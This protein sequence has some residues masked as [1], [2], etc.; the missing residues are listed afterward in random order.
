MQ[1]QPVER[2]AGPAR[3]Q[4]AEVTQAQHAQQAH[5][6]ERYARAAGFP[7]LD[8]A[9]ADAEEGGARLAVEETRVPQLAET[10]RAD[11]PDPAVPDRLRLT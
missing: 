8:G 3:V 2:P 6:R 5:H 9:Q 11:V 7:V 10:F 4:R 1:A